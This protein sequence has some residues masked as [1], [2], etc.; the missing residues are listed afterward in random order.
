MST[1]PVRL[2]LRAPSIVSRVAGL[3]SVFGKSIRDSRRATLVVGGSV[4]LLLLL[5]AKAIVGEFPTA[6]SRQQLVDLVAAVPPIMQGMAGKPVSVDTLG[7]YIQYK[8]GGFFPLVTG[9]W[10]I[11]ALSGTLA[12][13]ARRGS[14]EFVASSPIA[15]RQI[16][17]Q[18]LLGHVAM[19]SLAMAGVFAA[20]VLAGAALPV[21]P[22]DDISAT[23]AFGYALWLGLMALAAGSVAF[24]LAPFVGRSS[25]VGISSGVMVAGFLLNGYQTSI[26][27]F[28]PFANLTWFS[29]TG[30]H[31][32]LANRYDW[33][34]LA[35]VGLFAIVLFAVGVVAFARRDLGVTSAVPTPRLPRQLRGLGHAATRAAAEQSTMTIG[36]SIG[37]AIYGVTVAAAGRSFSEQLAN[38]PDLVAAFRGIFPTI[39]FATE[40]GFLELIFIELGLVMAGLAAATLVAVWASDETTGRLELLMATP[41]TRARWLVA[42]AF[43]VLVAIVVFTLVTAVAILVGAASA[44]GE[45]W[46]PVMGTFAIGFY[47][48][49]MAGIGFAVGGWFR[50]EWAAPT[51]AL[52]TILTW[53]D[54][55]LARDLKLPDFV[56]Q[57]A[58]S[59]HMGQPMVGVWDWPGIAACVVLGVGGVVVGAIGMRRRDIAR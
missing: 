38:S 3:G 50:T 29:W 56:A 27:A 40:G 57:I 24:A 33:L 26:P 14:L 35:L 7:G 32:P 49:A 55:F 44:G 21:L 2:A 58:L 53:L 51:V 15:R 34:S 9:L 42:G 11:L 39:D 28:G 12:G 20:T 25:A 31:I 36:W 30:N 18:K 54:A 19:M 4:G 22:G 10:S 52:V 45:V 43:G 16:A 13:E 17:L 5:V 41:L 23:A 6:A 59:T 8:Y 46:T 37:L 47:A 48:V 1:E